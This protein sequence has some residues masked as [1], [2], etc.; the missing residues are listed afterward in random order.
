MNLENDIIDSNSKFK[1]N[2]IPN[3]K[4]FSFMADYIE[5]QIKIEIITFKNLKSFKLIESGQTLN[6][7]IEFQN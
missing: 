6:G 5:V 1:L 4:C 3:L 7:E 2:I